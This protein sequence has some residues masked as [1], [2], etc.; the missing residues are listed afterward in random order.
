MRNSQIYVRI[1]IVPGKKDLEL[2]IN[3]QIPPYKELTTA[4]NYSGLEKFHNFGQ[5]LLFGRLSRMGE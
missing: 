4:L 5:Y 3:E 1:P 2:V